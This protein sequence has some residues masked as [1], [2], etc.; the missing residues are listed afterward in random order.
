[1]DSRSVVSTTKDFARGAAKVA[2]G[3]ASIARGTVQIASNLGK[4]ASLTAKMASDAAADARKTSTDATG[5]SSKNDAS[6]AFSNSR[7][8]GVVQ[9]VGGTA[10]AAVGVPML[11]LPGPGVAAIAGGATIAANGAR[12]AFGP[13]QPTKKPKAP[14]Q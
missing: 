1:M 2:R 9:M 4:A 6:D 14:E 5:R 7:T 8:A 11:I 10:L 3:S 12:K 13:N